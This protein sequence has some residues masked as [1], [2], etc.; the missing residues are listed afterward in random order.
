MTAA[1]PSGLRADALSLRPGS[2][3]AAPCLLV[4]LP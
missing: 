4:K 1:S 3:R 2:A